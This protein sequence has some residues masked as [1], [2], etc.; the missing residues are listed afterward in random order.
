MLFQ[1]VMRA[2]YVPVN[3]PGDAAPVQAQIA[4][5]AAD[6][7]PKRFASFPPPEASTHRR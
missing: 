2:A 6:W 1:L 5:L 4:Q 7:Q 3:G